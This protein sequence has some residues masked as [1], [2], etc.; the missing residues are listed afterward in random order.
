[1]S[2]G[3]DNRIEPVAGPFH[4]RLDL[5]LLTQPRS[6]PATARNLGAARSRGRFLAFTDDDCRPDPGWLVNLTAALETAPGDLVGGRTVNTLRPNL[7]S[8]A[9]QLLIDYLY[10]Y[11]NSDPVQARFLTSNN[12]ALAAANFRS[13]GGFDTS[14]PLAAGEDRDLCDRWLTC[15]GRIRYVPQAV[16]HHAH[17]LTLSGF[18]R[19]HFRYGRGAF[20]FHQARDRRG[21]GP[22]RVEPLGFYTDLIRFPLAHKVRGRSLALAALVALSQA[23]NAAGFFWERSRP[24]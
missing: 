20:H 17:H 12:L 16:V 21:Q 8:S 10:R 7:C 18:W 4:S 1:M 23:A 6:G 19:Q 3:A 9:S 13:L 15:G 11:Y 5:T 24:R 2:D 22:I 14:F